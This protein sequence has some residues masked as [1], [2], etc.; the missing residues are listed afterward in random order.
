M[1]RILVIDDDPG[2]LE[3]FKTILEVKG[4]EV[5]TFNNGEITVNEILGKSPNVILLDVYLKGSNG[6]ELCNR[7]K[8]D[9]LT[10]NIPVIMSSAQTSDYLILR[11]C[12]A[13]DFISKPIDI[14]DMIGKINNQI[15]ISEENINSLPSM[16]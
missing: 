8:A 13:Q 10:R 16:N 9:S 1:K 5:S 2:I 6:V 14:E 3:V 12:N 15:K 11:K 4:F 7:L